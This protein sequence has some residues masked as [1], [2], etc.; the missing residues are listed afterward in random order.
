MAANTQLVAST[1]QRLRLIALTVLSIL[2]LA[3]IGATFLQPAYANVP[4]SGTFTLNVSSAQP[5][6]PVS[7]AGEV[8]PPK[9]SSPGDSIFVIVFTGF[10]T[11][12][13]VPGDIGFIPLT[14]NLAP[15]GSVVGTFPGTT[16][17]TSGTFTIVV[18]S[19]FPAGSYTAQAYD[20]TYAANGVSAI[21]PC[22]TFTISTVIPEYPYG[23]AVLAI[24]MIVGC[25]VIRRRTM[26]RK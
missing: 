7:F 4:F 16:T 2:T 17:G 24:F 23:L 19:G 13:P 12:C 14:V 15:L 1:A 10:G 9:S 18:T 26:P 11:I 22:V 6:Q 21:S 20:N 25:G 8:N 5:N 3:I